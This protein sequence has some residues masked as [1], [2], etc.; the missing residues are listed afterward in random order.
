MQTRRTGDGY[1]LMDVG[2]ANS[3]AII[4]AGRMEHTVNKTTIVSSPVSL[5]TSAGNGPWNDLEAVFNSSQKMVEV[6]NA[7]R[8]GTLQFRATCCLDVMM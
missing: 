5:L 6:L 7:I 3:T 1:I 4:A 8:L 2:N